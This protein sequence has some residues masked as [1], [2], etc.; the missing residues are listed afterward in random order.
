MIW[1][2]LWPV[3]AACV[4]LVL[5]AF[6]VLAGV[7]LV[8]GLLVISLYGL[9]P[10]ET[11]FDSIR[12]LVESK[13][14]EENIQA[15]FQLHV[16]KSPPTTSIFI[17]Q[18]HG[19]ISI[20]SVLFNSLRIC[21]HPLYT[22]NHAVSMPFFHYLPVF[23]DIARYVGSI[24]SDYKN[25]EKTLN[26]KESVSIMLGGIREMM[27]AEPYHI[28][29]FI[30]KRTGIFRLALTTGTPIVPVLTY[31]ENELFP[32]LHNT[33]VDTINSTLYEKFGLY[34]PFT[35]WEA[36]QNWV[37]LSQKPLKPIHTHVGRP[38]RVIKNEHPSETDIHV[39]RTRYIRRI[40]NLF[41]QTAP[42]QYTLTIE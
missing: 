21:R 30:R 11:L 38:I 24:P 25:I 12:T 19:L 20:S 10:K 1:L 34:I 7:N 4:V 15:T 35:S 33:L 6:A 16:Q 14:I 41:K 23:G 22:P 39:L 8:L 36:L 17:W 5:V 26:K 13:E 31:G 28:K 27:T 37:Q 9:F 40:K 32:P 3:L 18:P 2:Y 42:S 29:L